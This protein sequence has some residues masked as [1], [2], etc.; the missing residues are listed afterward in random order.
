LELDFGLGAGGATASGRPLHNISPLIRDQRAPS[1]IPTPKSHWAGQSS[2]PKTRPNGVRQHF[3]PPAPVT[4]GENQTTRES[5]REPSLN[6]NRPE[7]VLGRRPR[8]RIVCH[9]SLLT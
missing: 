9:Y 5:D 1:G 3:P 6:P 4:A 8:S 7:A 2:G